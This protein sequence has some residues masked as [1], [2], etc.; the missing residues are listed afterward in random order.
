MVTV[1][2]AMA[3]LRSTKTPPGRPSANQALKMCRERLQNTP[4]AYVDVTQETSFNWAAYLARHPERQKIFR[5]SITRF[6]AEVF[7]ERDPSASCVGLRVDF[8]CVRA[9]GTAVRL[10]PHKHKEAIIMEGRLED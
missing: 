3:R 9:D 6:L 1:E 7:P 4:G 2:E 10:H 5:S 8:V